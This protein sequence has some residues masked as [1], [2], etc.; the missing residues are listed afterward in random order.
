VSFASGASSVSVINPSSSKNIASDN[1][2]HSE[3]LSVSKF[4]HELIIA[5]A[6]SS[7]S[8]G[9]LTKTRGEMA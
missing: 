6:P 3:S 2:K 4:R 7:V 5:M 9:E 1:W 8:D